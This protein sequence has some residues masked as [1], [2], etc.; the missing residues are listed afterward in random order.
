MDR[1]RFL[2]EYTS[3]SRTS[4][5]CTKC[6][7]GHFVFPVNVRNCSQGVFSQTVPCTACPA[8]FALAGVCRDHGGSRAYTL[9]Y[10]DPPIDFF[11]IPNGCSTQ[12]R[13]RVRTAFQLYWLN[14]DA[15]ANA[16]RSVVELILDNKRIAR[17]TSSAKRRTTHDRILEFHRTNP[18]AGELLLAMKWL[19]NQGSHASGK[20]SARTMLD[21]FEI[22]EQALALL[23]RGRITKLA[24]RINKQND[25]NRS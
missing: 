20:V 17:L 13:E 14:A 15:A 16:T 25:S 1:N 18:E 23:Y 5:A 21:D 22:L 7:R 8:R 3:A 9:R 6:G 2:R 24:K 10:V 4:F 11:E 12:L 19:G